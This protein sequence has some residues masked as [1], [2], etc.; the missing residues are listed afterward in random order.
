MIFRLTF[1]WLTI[2]FHQYVKASDTVFQR[3]TTRTELLNL[4]NDRKEKF[5][6]YSQSL[7]QKSGLFGNRT[8]G[9]LKDSQRYLMEI[10]E[11]DNKIMSTL[12]R[13]II[14]KNFEKTTMTYDAGANNDR[15][16]NLLKVNEALQKENERLLKESKAFT[17]E[18]NKSRIYSIIFAAAFF[19]LVYFNY[20]R[21]KKEKHNN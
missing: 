16:N 15:I 19:L 14:L 3:D 12:N 8:K 21:A 9:D 6:I 4:L 2:F 5:E 1:L 13:M 7:R 18:I 10:V 11:A 20:K 17:S